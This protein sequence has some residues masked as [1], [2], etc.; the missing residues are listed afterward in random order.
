MLKLSQT[1]KVLNEAFRQSLDSQSLVFAF[2]GL[3]AMVLVWQV[4]GVMLLPSRASVVHATTEVSPSLRRASDYHEKLGALTN[5]EALPSLFVSSPAPLQPN[6]ERPIDPL[7]AGWRFALP[8]RQLFVVGQSWTTFF[9]YLF[10][11]VATIFVWSYCGLPIARLT[12]LKISR[13]KSQTIGEALSYAKAKGFD[14]VSAVILPLIAVAMISIPAIPLGW[15]MKFDF[16]LLIAGCLWVLV[17]VVA[18]LMAVLAFGLI[19]GWPLMWGAVA[20]DDC[21][22]FDAISRAYAYALQRPLHY[23]CY[24]LVGL[25]V[26]CLGWLVAWSLAELTVGLGFWC[27]ELG[28]GAERIQEVLAAIR[29]PIGELQSGVSPPSGVS[30]SG[31]AAIRFACNL[32]RGVASAY[33]FSFFF[34]LAASI[35][36]LLR[37][38]IDETELDQI[39]EFDS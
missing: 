15:A 4:L 24:V 13:E 38:D 3:L 16:G 19:L 20:A 32:L 12:V 17:L 28:C 25:V 34:S 14:V 36:L 9:Y 18:A 37:R 11:S 33:S 8:V 10:G 6:V 30:P 22:A 27:V 7:D 1:W 5:R 26:G 31:I 29:Q 35:Y 21:D 23:L 2:V 39:F